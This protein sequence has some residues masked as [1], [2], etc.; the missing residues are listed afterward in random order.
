M[1]NRWFLTAKTYSNCGGKKEIFSLGERVF[2]FDS[3]GFECDRD[4]N[5]AINL[6]HCAVSKAVS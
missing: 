1:I 6:S 4:L 3:C 2:K 5:A